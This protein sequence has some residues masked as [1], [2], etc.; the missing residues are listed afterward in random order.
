MAIKV[1]KRSDFDASRKLPMLT[2]D[3]L[4]LREFAFVDDGGQGI[5]VY[6]DDGGEVPVDLGGVATLDSV[7]SSDPAVML[8]LD[9]RG[10]TIEMSPRSVGKATISFRLIHTNARYRAV[11]FVYDAEVTKAADSAT[12]MFEVTHNEPRIVVDENA[13][14]EA[15]MSDAEKERRANEAARRKTEYEKTAV[16]QKDAVRGSASAAAQTA[17]EEEQQQSQ[18]RASSRAPKKTDDGGDKKG[19]KGE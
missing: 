8:V 19:E 11:R 12:G 7:L 18:Q 13:P 14:K 5:T 2:Y 3:D 16:P 6:G 17:G 9:V 4:A 10:M 15:D 1:M